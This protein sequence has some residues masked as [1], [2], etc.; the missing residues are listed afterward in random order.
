MGVL[1]FHCLYV[2]VFFIVYSVFIK[3]TVNSRQL[4]KFIDV[5]INFFAN[6]IVWLFSV[7][8]KSLQCILF[9]VLVLLY[10]L[11]PDF[12]RKKK[13][14]KKRPRFIVVILAAAQW[15]ETLKAAGTAYSKAYFRIFEF[16]KRVKQEVKKKICFIFKEGFKG[17]CLSLCIFCQYLW[18]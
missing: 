14:T 10:F 16:W 18:F 12:L 1:L 4:S 6:Q 5:L 9:G 15:V 3:I 2:C 7:F 17:H 8:V 11:V 13:N